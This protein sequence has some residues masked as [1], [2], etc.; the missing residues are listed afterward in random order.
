MKIRIRKSKSEK[1]E[2]QTEVILHEQGN[3][4]QGVGQK[5]V[6]V[7]TKS[8]GLGLS[9]L[10]FQRMPFTSPPTWT[11][12]R[13]CLLHHHLHEQIPGGAFHITV[14]MNRFQGVPFTTPSAWTVLAK[15]LSCACSLFTEALDIRV[16]SE[17]QIH[18]NKELKGKGKT[19]RRCE[20][21]T[22][23]WFK[24]FKYSL[25]WRAFP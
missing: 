8:Q 15:V 19:G 1:L 6:H 18:R 24:N 2:K 11:D 12:S 13:G 7:G 25:S 16:R 4:K 23:R 21:T 20:A 5:T 9:H 14:Y 10:T 3:L 22:L 17:V